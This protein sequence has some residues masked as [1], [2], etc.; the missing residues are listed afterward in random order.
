MS[1]LMTTMS[2]DP[3]QKQVIIIPNGYIGNE[4]RLHW[5]LKFG[6]SCQQH[7]MTMPQFSLSQ[8]QRQNNN[9]SSSIE[10]QRFIIATLL[11]YIIEGDISLKEYLKTC[12]PRLDFLNNHELVCFFRTV[13]NLFCQYMYFIPD[14]LVLWQKNRHSFSSLGLP[15]KW[16]IRLWQSLYHTFPEY[17]FNYASAFLKWVDQMDN[18]PP[19]KEPIYFFGDIFFPKWIKEGIKKL[20]RDSSLYFYLLE[21]LHYFSPK[22]LCY[23]WLKI[24]G[25]LVSNSYEMKS[26]K[27][28][29]FLEAIQYRMMAKEENDL[30]DNNDYLVVQD[31]PSFQ[32][33][34]CHT[35]NREIEV[36][37]H[38]TQ[39]LL[40][41]HLAWQPHDIAIVFSDIQTYL[42]PLKTVFD[43]PPREGATI[44]YICCHE[45][46]EHYKIKDLLNFI[47]SIIHKSPV[48]DFLKSIKNMQ[49][50]QLFQLN[51][52]DVQTI[53]YWLLKIN[54]IEDHP[55]DMP[56]VRSLKNCLFSLMHAF[57]SADNINSIS[58][59][60]PFQLDIVLTHRDTIRK[61]SYLVYFCESIKE[62]ANSCYSIESWIEKIEDIFEGLSISWDWL[63]KIRLQM[64][65]Y[66]L[67]SSISF[68]EIVEVL[69]F[70]LDQQKYSTNRM[71][72][73]VKLIPL[74]M[75]FPMPYKA[76]ICVGTGHSTIQKKQPSTFLDILDSPPFKEDAPSF[77]VYW[78]ALLN[79]IRSAEQCH[80]SIYSRMSPQKQQEELSP[81]W[82]QWLEQHFIT[83]LCP[84]LTTTYITYHPLFSHEYKENT[85][86]P[87]YIHFNALDKEISLQQKNYN[88]T[89]N[90]E[91]VFNIF[92]IINP[93]KVY[94][95]QKKNTYSLEEFISFFATPSKFYCSQHYIHPQIYHADIP[96][97]EQWV[98][99]P[100]KRSFIRRQLWAQ[101][102]NNHYIWDNEKTQDIYYNLLEH[103]FLAYGSSGKE[104]YSRQLTMIK[105]VLD[106][107]YHLLGCEP[108]PCHL[109]Y[110]TNQNDFIINGIIKSFNHPIQCLVDHKTSLHKYPSPEMIIETWLYH[111]LTTKL[112]KR[113]TQ[114]YLFFQRDKNDH[115]SQVKFSEISLLEAH[116]Q[117]DNLIRIFSC[118]RHKPSF[119]MPRLGIKL[120]EEVYI[121]NEPIKE[122]KRK[123][124]LIWDNPGYYD[125]NY[126][127]YDY[128]VYRIVPLE[129]ELFIK[130]NCAIWK[131]IYNYIYFS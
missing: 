131:P 30:L 33:H 68:K 91:N 89:S 58:S 13:S 106:R 56:Y 69:I 50:Q 112:K 77:T 130:N 29:S 41:D 27:S 99:Y 39:K 2:K 24:N 73:G 51:R 64:S 34:C 88:T 117:L 16:Q 102:Q 78:N 8:V 105:E 103:G 44:P 71:G 115:I 48:S 18:Y 19:L 93:S 94:A 26:N 4:L 83:P 70:E 95:Y 47:Y 21:P 122:W 109:H 96:I 20:S 11:K 67:S 127:S 43:L 3:F 65:V 17:P 98:T 110:Y 42:I 35:P 28:H 129:S 92:P 62:L 32:I 66:T 36:C 116:K 49:I 55:D 63:R 31:D 57:F 82:I 9:A 10:D 75:F 111:L 15:E 125:S 6:I 60:L 72:G 104:E 87:F 107:R 12:L 45:S 81:E 114:T 38:L 53:T 123:N 54:Y 97:H 84:S 7:F 90:P 52:Y 1:H 113:S 86:S 101:A 85:S 119:L 37:Y 74:K 76:I 120:M 108:I 22:N 124:Q 100:T 23:Q 80:I 79:T 46:V 126:T 40:E 59:I 121:K 25:T 5:S 61:L 128:K 118:Y 14:E